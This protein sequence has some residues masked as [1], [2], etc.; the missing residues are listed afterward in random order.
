M[1]IK[2]YSKLFLN[3][4]N[5][6]EKE[7]KNL[8][9]HR[10]TQHNGSVS[11]LQAAEHHIV[12]DVKFYVVHQLKSNVHIQCWNI[13]ARKRVF[14]TQ[15]EKRLFA[16]FWFGNWMNWASAYANKRNK[17]ECEL[18]C[19]LRGEL[20]SQ[21][22]VWAAHC[23]RVGSVSSQQREDGCCTDI[24]SFG[25]SSQMN[26][27]FIQHWNMTKWIIKMHE[28]LTKLFYSTFIVPLECDVLVNKM[29]HFRSKSWK[30]K[31]LRTAS[32]ARRRREKQHAKMS[33]VFFGGELCPV[34]RRENVSITN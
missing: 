15:R 18:L 12:W 23:N 16:A 34:W 29:K 4:R 19:K 22:A 20:S 6:Q 30:W 10:T 33:K 1:Q 14:W 31:R 13:I 5:V 11:T 28:N 25:K 2:T 21:C 9:T 27:Y 17:G 3:V 8:N 24:L 26:T 32:E 7:K